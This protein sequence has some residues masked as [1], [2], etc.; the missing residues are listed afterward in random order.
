[1]QAARFHVDFYFGAGSRYSYLA[2][3]QLSR[4]SEET[5]A[6]FRWKAV[7]SGD[8]IAATGRDPFAPDQ[9]RGPYDPGYRTQDV[10][11]WA[12]LYRVPFTDFDVAGVDLRRLAR[13]CCAAD[14]LG[15]AE[16]FGR[17]LLQAVHGRGEP[18]RNDAEL[19]A[20]AVAAGLD[21]RELIRVLESTRSEQQQSRNLEDARAAG[22]FGVPTFVTEDGELFWGQD[23]LPLL[24]AHLGG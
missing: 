12:R 24:Q 21:P 13:A 20:V 15:R 4:L 7:F 19:A 6:V 22:A 8:L 16:G 9:Q 23:R 18:P 17:A 3:T 10:E 1:M 11:R 5:A 2:S 14:L